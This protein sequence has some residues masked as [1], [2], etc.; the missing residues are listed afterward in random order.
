M[1]LDQ[2]ANFVR[3]EVDESVDD[4][5]TTILVADISVFPD[6]VDGEYNCV[7][8][9]VGEFPRPNEDP[10]VEIVRVTGIDASQLVVERGVE[11]TSAAAH[12]NTSEIQLAPTAKVIQDVSVELESLED[13]KADNEDVSSIQE[14]ADVNHDETSSRTHEGDGISPAN[15]SVDSWNKID[16]VEA[17]LSND[18]T[19]DTGQFIFD[20]ADDDTLLI[21]PPGTYSFDTSAEVEG[22]ENFG[23]VCPTGRA[24]FTEGDI[25]EGEEMIKLGSVANPVESFV[26]EGFTTDTVQAKFV[27]I[28]GSGVVE[29]IRFTSQKGVSDQGATHHISARVFDDEKTLVFKDVLMPEGGEFTETLSEAAGG[30]F[31]HD[32]TAGTVRFIDCVV[33]GFPDNGIYASTPAETDGANGSIHV[34]GGRFKN[35]NISGVRIGGNGSSIRNAEFIFDD[36]NTDFTGVRGVYL[37]NG[38]GHLVEN[39]RFKTATDTEGAVHV[40]VTS[41]CGSAVLKNNFHSDDGGSRV[42]RVNAHSESDRDN[43]VIVDGLELVGDGDDEQYPVFIERGFCKLE[44]LL[45]NQPNR[46][47][48]WVNADDV[49]LE[50]SEIIVGNNRLLDDG[51][52]LVENGFSRNDGDPND[53][54]EWNGEFDLAINRGVVIWDTSEEN[55]VR[56]QAIED[57]G[58]VEVANNPHDNDAHSETYTTADD[59]VEDFAT[60][61]DE[62]TVPVSQGDG[63]VVMDEVGGG[64]E[65][66][67]TQDDAEEIGLYYVEDEEALTYRFGQW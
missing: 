36:P 55:S 63:S 1:V 65:V 26:I 22:V 41:N 37:R 66:V 23:L 52:R 8:W 25:E 33:N 48:V 30:F 32:T 49:N 46:S 7:V 38:S 60:E 4:E 29:D 16:V 53:E 20:N 58:F 35:N 12:P 19:G 59:N 51:L 10:N 57:E 50:N 67:S 17:G 56:Y 21:F 44:N 9:D 54:G 47:G 2:V 62:G 45:I 40:N 42:L 3:D 15:L 27:D 11:G 31:I 13:N 28:F 24:L 5:Q 43:R 14:S 39:N 61:G 64:V 18:G 6:P 34:E